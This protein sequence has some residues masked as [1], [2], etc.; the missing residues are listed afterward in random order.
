MVAGKTGDV[1]LMQRWRSFKSCTCKAICCCWQTSDIW[2]KQ[3]RNKEKYPQHT[4]LPWHKHKNIR[5]TRPG[6]ERLVLRMPS[7]LLETNEIDICVCCSRTIPVHCSM[8]LKAATRRSYV[9]QKLGPGGTLTGC[10]HSL[11]HRWWCTFEQT[12]CVT[13]TFFQC[14]GLWRRTFCYFSSFI[15]TGFGFWT[16]GVEMLKM[17]IFVC[18]SSWQ[19]WTWTDVIHPIYCNC[20]V[21]D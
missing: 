1:F 13:E 4:F 15:T 5:D 3:L 19:K 17:F 6:P 16:D 14:C 2:K 7:S 10:L 9:H 11:T 20:T 12:G 21:P 8:S 18:P